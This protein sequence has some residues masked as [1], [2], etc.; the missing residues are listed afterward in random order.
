MDYQKL[1]LEG[2]KGKALL[3]LGKLS[4]SESSVP[5]ILM[6]DD[7][8]A[9]LQVLG[10]IL[11]EQY[12]VYWT[13]NPRQVCALAERHMPDL[14]LLDIMM[15]EMSGYDVIKLLKSNP[16]TS[17]IPVIFVTALADVQ[18]EQMGFAHQ[19]VDY[20]TKPVNAAIV[21]ARVKTHLSL[22]RSDELKNT[23]MEIIRCLGHAAEFKDNETGR[24]VIRMSEYSSILASAIGLHYDDCELIRNA[25]PMHDIGKIGIPDQVLL[26]PGKLDQDEWVIMKRHP[27][28]GRDIL[29]NQDSPLLRLAAS[30]AYTHHEKWNG[31][32]YP[33]GLKGEE[34]PL[35]GR[36][37]AIADVF[38]ALT[39]SRPYK[40]AWPIEK[41]IKLLQ[42]EA[43]HHFDPMLVPL[44]LRRIEDVLE[45]RELW[46]DNNEPEAVQT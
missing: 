36:I 9:N 13:K 15:P 22:V 14:I 40:Q 39:T 11:G 38:D 7:E 3:K 8:P 16:V 23:R 10:N 28:I 2:A 37:I 19:A 1:Q 45:V 33:R 4:V 35:E 32:G 5:K 21:L 27:E 6:V 18:D 17:H 12:K 20:I 43:G 24:H 26:K 29:G 25:A 30:I 31:E 41:A 44:F 42:D 46:L 34:I